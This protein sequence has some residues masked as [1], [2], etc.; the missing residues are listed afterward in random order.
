MTCRRHGLIA[1]AC[2]A[3]R[4]ARS[5][6]WRIGLQPRSL[7]VTEKWWFRWD[8]PVGHSEDLFTTLRCIFLQ[9][10]LVEPLPSRFCVL[11]LILS[12]SQAGSIRFLK[13]ARETN[14]EGSNQCRLVEARDVLANHCE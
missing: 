10:S 7:R 5:G 6:R 9:P 2:A 4:A 11:R 3:V 13:P 1:N 14:A 12:V 8:L